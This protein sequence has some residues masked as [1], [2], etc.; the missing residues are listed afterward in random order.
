MRLFPKAIIVDTTEP[1]IDAIHSLTSR[2]GLMVRTIALG[3]TRISA[4]GEF[5]KLVTTF[6]FVLYQ[7]YNPRLRLN[8]L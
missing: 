3:K 1:R 5:N 6:E 8:T 7:I 2:R 4:I